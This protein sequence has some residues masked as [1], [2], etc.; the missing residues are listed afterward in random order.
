MRS[1]FSI[2]GH[3]LH[4]LLVA[5]PIGLFVWAFV[6]DIVYV[7]SDNQTWYDISFWSGIAAIVTALVA[8]APGLGD[9][10]T[11]AVHSDARV[12]ATA[13]LVLN[14]AVIIL[15]AAAAALQAGNGA[16]AG[17]SLTAVVAL[18]GIGVGML[19]ISGALGGEMVYRHHLG[20]IPDDG[21]QEARELARHGHG[22][23]MH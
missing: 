4:P 23:A 16:L 22:H 15:F 12:I 5:A 14:V 10:L 17:S 20:V 7:A 1:R 11:M 6:A 18:H 13:H 2:R 8:A 19:A 9:Y 3:P 21:E